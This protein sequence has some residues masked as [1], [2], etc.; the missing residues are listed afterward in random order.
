[1]L[2]AAT[3]LLRYPPQL[4]A[5]A[6]EQGFTQTS[7]VCGTAIAMLGIAGISVPDL[8]VKRP[9]CEYTPQAGLFLLVAI[10]AIREFTLPK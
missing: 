9:A 3:T 7:H 8:D 10:T 4:T 2:P 1:M 6:N 5:E